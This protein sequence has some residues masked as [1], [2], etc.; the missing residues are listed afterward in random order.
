MQP[1][2]QF[3]GSKRRL[4]SMVF[5]NSKRLSSLNLQD[6]KQCLAQSRY[7]VKSYIRQQGTHQRLRR[8][9]LSPTHSKLGNLVFGRKN[10]IILF[11]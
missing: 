6:L 3:K 7:S 4:E 11:P 5:T 10:I 8:I 9:C 1:F 2:F